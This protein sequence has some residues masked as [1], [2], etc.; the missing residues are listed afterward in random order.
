M[1][2]LG[3]EAKAQTDFKDPRDGAV[4]PVI[5]LNGLLW[6][7]ENLRFETDSSRLYDN[8]QRSKKC[9]QFYAIVEAFEV[10]PAGWRLPTENE[11][12]QLIKLDKRDKVDLEDTLQVDK[13]GRIDSQ[14][15]SKQG[16]QNTYWIQVELKGTYAT[17]WHFFTDD[18][19]M[20][21]HNVSGRMFPVRC[22]K[23][24]D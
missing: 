5:E 13:C 10:C 18:N 15:A 19:H 23:G 4:Y 11:V 17:H 14:K 3:F 22:V 2:I 12:K 21:H 9:G 6:F 8:S 16:F 1:F 7:Q 24:L 20:H